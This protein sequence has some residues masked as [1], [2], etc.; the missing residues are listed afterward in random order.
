[1]L[2]RRGKIAYLMGMDDKESGQDAVAARVIS[3]A[4][5]AEILGMGR[6]TLHRDW[7][8]M[9]LPFYRPHPT[10]RKWVVRESAV[11]AY[12]REREQAQA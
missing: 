1:M 7:R 9:G 11:R 5:A 10:L 12:M 3:M 4:R 8:L 6:S 2:R